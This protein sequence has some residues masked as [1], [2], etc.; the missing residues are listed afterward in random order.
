MTTGAPSSTKRL[1]DVEWSKERRTVTKA[2][3]DS[4]MRQTARRTL[5]GQDG[6]EQPRGQ[7]M[8]RGVL[9]SQEVTELPGRCQ[10]ASRMPIS[11][12]SA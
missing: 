5:N 9:N 2:P 8:I 11:N 6:A 10:T 7:R 3:I 1:D 12:E 4:G